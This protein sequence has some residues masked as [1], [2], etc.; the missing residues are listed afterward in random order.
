MNVIDTDTTLWGVFT[1]ATVISEFVF[2]EK[3]MLINHIIKIGATNIIAKVLLSL[4]NS[5]NTLFEIVKILMLFFL[6]F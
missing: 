6:H 3:T 2:A 4:K 5:L 1:E